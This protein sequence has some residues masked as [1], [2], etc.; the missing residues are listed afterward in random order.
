MGRRLHKLPA[1]GARL[2]QSRDEPLPHERRQAVDQAVAETP[3]SRYEIREA[4]AAAQREQGAFMAEMQARA[5]SRGEAEL[6]TAKPAG[7]RGRFLGAQHLLAARQHVQAKVATSTYRQSASDDEDEGQDDEVDVFVRAPGHE[8][9]NDSDQ[10]SLPG[11]QRSSYQYKP[12]LTGDQLIGWRCQATFPTGPT[13][14][15]R[16]HPGYVFQAKVEL[17]S[18]SR[19]QSYRLFFPIDQAEEWVQEASRQE[20]LLLQGGD[21]G[22]GWAACLSRGSSACALCSARGVRAMVRLAMVRLGLWAA[23]VG[24]G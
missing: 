15:L 17:V 11:G 3:L 5:V 2:S 9:I 19:V 18:G 16:W 14:E 21:R 10:P 8:A 4:A 22:S 12:P 1:C 6:F 13:R 24:F 23:C 20:R 7:A